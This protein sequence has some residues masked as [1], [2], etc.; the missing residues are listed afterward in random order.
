M[1]LEK[2]LFTKLS[3]QQPKSLGLL[4]KIN[5]HSLFRLKFYGILVKHQCKTKKL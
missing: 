5:T 4:T 1:L 2:E 3:L